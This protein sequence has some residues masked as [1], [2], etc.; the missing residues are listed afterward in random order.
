MD[1]LKIGNF[2]ILQLA[3]TDILTDRFF[4]K[5]VRPHL[6]TSLQTLNMI[7][8][9]TKYGQSETTCTYLGLT[10]VAWRKL[11]PCRRHN[12]RLALEARAWLDNPRSIAYSRHD[13]RQKPRRQSRRPAERPREGIACTLPMF[14]QEYRGPSL[15]PVRLSEDKV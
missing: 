8:K 6:K 12:R 11:Q 5:D 7:V 1:N 13:C 14:G 15:F 2:D 3:N 4:Y 10:V 9:K